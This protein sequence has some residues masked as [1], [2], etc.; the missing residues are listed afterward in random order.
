MSKRTWHQNRGVDA[1][2][3]YTCST[4]QVKGF[5]FVRYLINSTI[6]KFDVKILHTFLKRTNSKR[7]RFSYIQVKETILNLDNNGME[8]WRSINIPGTES[9]VFIQVKVE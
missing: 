6:E 1:M 2:M 9:L 5:L 3:W 4:L 7:K 8:M